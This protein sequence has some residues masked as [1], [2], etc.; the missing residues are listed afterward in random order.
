MVNCSYCG[1]EIDRRVFCKPSHKVLFHQRKRNQVEDVLEKVL[2]PEEPKID[3]TP[4]STRDYTAFMVLPEK[5]KM[6]GAH[7]YVPFYQKGKR[8]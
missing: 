2:M 4:I 1:K 8:K 7:P 5:P 3:P 6:D